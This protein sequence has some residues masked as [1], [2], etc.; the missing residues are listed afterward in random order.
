M[1]AL[2]PVFAPLGARFDS[3]NSVVL[4]FGDRASEYRAL[5]SGRGVV[6]LWDRTQIEIR[7][8]DRT[9]VLN[10]LCT[11]DIANREPGQGCEAFITNVKG[12][13]V[14]HVLIFVGQDSVVLE[15]TPGQA[16]H[17]MQHIDRYILREDAELHDRSG[18]WSQLLISGPEA[19]SSLVSAGLDPLPRS[20]LEHTHLPFEGS[21]LSLRRVPMTGSDA[22]LIAASDQEH[23]L[24]LW[25]QIV[26]A[27]A[28]PCGVAA[29]EVTRVEA[30]WPFFGMDITEKNL[31]Q[32]IDRNDQAIS[33]R[34]GCYLGQE[35]VARIDALGHVNRTLTGLVFSAD[36]PAS[37]HPAT[38]SLPPLG[39]QL[40]A[41]GKTMGQVT[42]AVFSPVLQQPL[43]MGYVRRGFNQPSQVLESASGAA[44]VVGLPIRETKAD[45]S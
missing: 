3:T 9:K 10:N 44:T 11:N 7:G 22:F 17:L 18:E 27:G 4:D 23:A 25:K 15:T 19:A 34:K 43:A 5:T 8:A 32:E 30:G 14:G 40:T 20:L 24:S 21:W 39:L 2:K 36:S 26:A 28:Q 31:P 13:T 38:N 29:L 35:T 1:S 45:M 16:T 42:S 12:H 33:F 37:E 41:G 6:P